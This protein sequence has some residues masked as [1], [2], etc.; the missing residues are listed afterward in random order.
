[1]HI[2][3]GELNAFGDNVKPEMVVIVDTCIILYKFL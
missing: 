2:R 3:N 1:M